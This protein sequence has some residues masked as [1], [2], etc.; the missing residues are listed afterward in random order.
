MKKMGLID[1]EEDADEET[2]KRFVGLFDH[3]LSPQHVTALA[4]LL[5]VD[6]AQRS[7]LILQ[8][9]LGS[10]P[11]PMGEGSRNIIASQA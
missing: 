9:A 11:S 2:L 7:P 5:D 4:E 6:L 8:P 10:Q 1:K 3:P